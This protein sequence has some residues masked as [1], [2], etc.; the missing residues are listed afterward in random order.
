MVN[1]TNLCTVLLKEHY[2]HIVWAFTFTPFHVPPSS[3]PMY[4]PPPLPCT[5]TCLPL[6]STYPPPPSTYHAPSP[7]TYHPS[8]PFHI[9]PPP[10]PHTS[11]SPFYIPPPPPPLHPIL[12][13]HTKHW[14]C[15]VTSRA[16]IQRSSG[17]TPW[18]HPLHFM[19]ELVTKQSLQYSCPPS[20]LKPSPAIK[21]Q[22]SN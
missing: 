17:E 2:T 19:P 4:Y 5:S 15:Q 21:Q 20:K 18:P 1:F 6:H 10:L 22:N 16:S 9:P 3:P 14:E 7:S 13:S 11:S 12:T 8:S